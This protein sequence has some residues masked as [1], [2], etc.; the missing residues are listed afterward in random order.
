MYLSE[1]FIKSEPAKILANKIRSETVGDSIPVD[2]EKI[3]CMNDTKIIF[4]DMEKNILGK[5]ALIKNELCIVINKNIEK[6]KG[7]KRFTI[8][9]EL[10]HII[11]ETH[12]TEEYKKASIDIN[13]PHKKYISNKFEREANEFASHLIIPEKHF[14]ERLKKTKN[15]DNWNT[16]KNIC[17]E[18]ETSL[19]SLAIRYISQSREIACFIIFDTSSNSIKTLSYSEEFRNSKFFIDRKS[20]SLPINSNAFILNSSN[21]DIISIMKIDNWFPKTTKNNCEITEHSFIYDK[22]QIYILLV[23]KNYIENDYSFI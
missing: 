18:Y 6:S 20:F 17:M 12:N 21:K 4:E 7:R 11:F 19:E 13:N 22:T 9:H 14:L 15:L 5:T 2:V 3:C 23:I 16:I 8:A 10:G 1:F